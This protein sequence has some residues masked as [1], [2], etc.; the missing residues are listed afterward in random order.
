MKLSK[1]KSNN[2]ALKR[3]PPRKNRKALSLFRK[4]KK[5]GSKRREIKSPERRQEIKT[6]IVTT[7]L[8]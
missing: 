1:K 7:A 2:N 4:I 3:V 8:I 6:T 5:K